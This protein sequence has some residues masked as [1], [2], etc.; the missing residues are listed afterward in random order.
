MVVIVGIGNPG[1]K[2]CGTYHNMGFETVDALA[3]KIG[4]SIDREKYKALVGEGFID[5]E[6]VLLV[7]PQTY[8]NLSGECVSM[9]RKKF[10]DARILVVVDD[11]D[12]PQG[13]VR[14]RLRGSGG[15]HNG[16]RSIVSYI[17]QDFERVKIGIGRDISKDLA[18]Y[19]L[20]R[21]DR[22]FFFPVIE[23]AVEMVCQKVKNPN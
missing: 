17:G 4:V 20:S 5:G 10:R 19:V 14:Y 3:K 18:D 8:V 1:Q 22:N 23:K 2:Y 21:F 7:K 11:I 15:T 16:L 9:I 6:K 12:L 13:Y